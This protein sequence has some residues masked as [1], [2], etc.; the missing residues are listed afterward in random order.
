MDVHALKAFLAVARE[1]SFS[2][3]ASALSR[4]QPAVSLAVQRLEEE[5]DAALID[6]RSRTVLLTEAG[7]LLVSC[8]ERVV[9][10]IEEA[11]CALRTLSDA[12]SRQVIVG[13]TASTMETVLPAIGHLQRTH[14]AIRIVVRH[15]DADRIAAELRAGTIQF[16][17]RACATTTATATAAATATAIEMPASAILISSDELVALVPPSHRLAKARSLNAEQLAQET[18]MLLD[19]YS[20]PLRPC[21]AAPH[22]RPAMSMPSVDAI[23]H[24]VQMGIGVAV[25]PRRCA[26]MEIQSGR[27]I[28]IAITPASTQHVYLLRGESERL[29]EPAKLFLQAVLTT[30][31]EEEE[32][33]AQ[34]QVVRRPL[35]AVGRR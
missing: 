14:P 9:R 3:A 20:H 12:T 7:E 31:K 33:A 1:R 34:S 17:V 21:V 18:V 23:K 35:R 8:G 19:D 28:A 32:V 24:A 5:L 25:L 6:R 4:S 29:P 26:L 30:I 16:G 22:P 27:L 2:R 11:E 10:A 15:V 13:V